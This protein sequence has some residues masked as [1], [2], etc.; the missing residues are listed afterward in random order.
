VVVDQKALEPL[1][2]V[3][4]ED[5]LGELADAGVGAVHDLAVGELLLEHRPADADA[6]QGLRVERDRLALTGDSHEL[7][8]RERGSVQNDGHGASFP[9]ETIA[10]SRSAPEGLNPTAPQSRCLDTSCG[11]GVP[12]VDAAAGVPAVCARK[13]SSGLCE[14]A[15]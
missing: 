5:H 12:A 14:E 2:L 6:L 11:G 1:Y 13:R 9:R 4:V 15:L 8:Y 3:V 10:D 7:L